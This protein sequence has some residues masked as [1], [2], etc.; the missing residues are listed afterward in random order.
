MVSLT[1]WVTPGRVQVPHLESVY[2]S[3][4]NTWD[5]N[6][7]NV[8]PYNYGALATTSQAYQNINV[9]IPTTYNQYSGCP[10]GHIMGADG[11]CRL[12]PNWIGAG[13]TTG[14]TTG[15]TATT[16]GTTADTTAEAFQT[17][18]IYQGGG[19]PDADPDVGTAGQWTGQVTG[20]TYA[21]LKGGWNNWS[22]ETFYDYGLDKGYFTEDGGLVGAMEAKL[23]GWMG[24]LG[25]WANDKKFNAWLSD[26]QKKGIFKLSYDTEGNLEDAWLM[27]KRG[28]LDN[29]WGGGML[30]DI[31]KKTKETS[32]KI[33][34]SL[35]AEDVREIPQYDTRTEYVPIKWQRII[36]KEYPLGKDISWEEKEAEIKLALQATNDL[37][38]RTKKSDTGYG[39]PLIA[40]LEKEI[41]AFEEQLNTGN[42]ATIK[43]EQ[44]FDPL[45]NKWVKKSPG[46]MAEK[47]RRARSEKLLAG[48][49]VAKE[50]VIQELK[51]PKLLIGTVE[52]NKASNMVT[53]SAGQYVGASVYKSPTSV[54]A[55]T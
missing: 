14:T 33:W 43:Q 50:P 49:Q 40:S 12:D 51:K 34:Q 39:G 1:P 19:Q 37:L 44:M 5:I 25:Q 20:N 46:L 2:D 53:A 6:P 31:A 24:T 29:E 23:P 16:T 3:V 27:K 38:E 22:D 28:P 10:A 13:T 36:N 4:T 9:G 8:S 52:G 32:E 15:T 47:E 26:A 17:A 45:L 54:D 42:F 55:A 11:V 30:E 48:M 7:V 18:N 21:N 35:V 41:A